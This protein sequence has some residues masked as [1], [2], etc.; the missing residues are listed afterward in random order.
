M[1]PR[2]PSPAARRAV[3]S[4]YPPPP[5]NVKRARKSLRRRGLRESRCAKQSATYRFCVAYIDVIGSIEVSVQIV[6]LPGAAAPKPESLGIG[7]EPKQRYGEEARDCPIRILPNELLSWQEKNRGK[8]LVAE[9]VE[10]VIGLS[11]VRGRSRWQ[12]QAKQKKHGNFMLRLSD[13]NLTIAEA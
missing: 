9:G 3:R 7:D 10:P 1:N 8:H 13:L 6:A 2:T 12:A 5:I 4:A 11:G